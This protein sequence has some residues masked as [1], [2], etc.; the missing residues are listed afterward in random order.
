MREQK[1]EKG[2]NR[3]REKCDRSEGELRYINEKNCETKG[4]RE[5]EV[6]VTKERV[7]EEEE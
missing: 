2:D 5:G 3:W 7:K 6:C 1:D 4:L